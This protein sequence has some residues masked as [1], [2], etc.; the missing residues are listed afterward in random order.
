MCSNRCANPVRPA[1]S[2]ADPTWYHRFTATIGAVWSSDSVTNNPFGNRK[3]S[4]GRRMV[5]NCTS[6]DGRGTPTYVSS[7]TMVLT[8]VA[9]AVGALLLVALSVGAVW[10]RQ[11]R[12][13]YQ[14]PAE[15]PAPPRG[16]KRVD[17]VAS[18]EQP[19][20]AY[21]IE[22]PEGTSAAIGMLIAFHG[23]ADLATWQIDWAREIA[24]RANWC[25]MLAEYRGYGGLLGAPDYEGVRRDARATW[26]VACE[27]VAS[28]RPLVVFG[29][30][31][32]S[33][34]AV[35][36]ATELIDQGAAALPV[37][38]LLQSPFTSAREMARIVST[39]PVHALWNLIARVHYDT[40]EKLARLALPVWIAHGE[41]D[42]LVPVAMGRELHE[43][44]RLPGQLLLVSDAGH[45]DVDQRGATTYWQW[46][47]DALA[48]AAMGRVVPSSGDQSES[49]RRIGTSA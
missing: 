13:A 16:V 34:I 25:V 7:I 40:R 47:I 29:H 38:L 35:E 9:V 43:T 12:I 45:N 42:W 5:V 31:L 23:N 17:F 4:I 22:P 21:V 18:D 44:C 10:W 26:D 41:R 39:R 15:N 8:L 28:S 24:R 19:L 11:E 33:A 37:M 27:M 1:R 30:S 32:G 49:R 14:P 2:F 36:L 6:P 46:M 20:Y 48:A 3:V